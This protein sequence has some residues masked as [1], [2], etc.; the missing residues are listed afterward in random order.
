[1]KIL[2]R[3]LTENDFMEWCGLWQK[4]LTFYE[5]FKYK[6]TKILLKR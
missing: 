2:I 4:Y 6:I 3:S 1:M 5:K